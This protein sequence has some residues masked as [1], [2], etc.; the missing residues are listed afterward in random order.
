[1]A[2]AVQ[3]PFEQIQKVGGIMSL[4]DE[5][6][7]KETEGFVIMD[8]TTKSDGLGG[9]ITVWKEGAPVEVALQQDTATGKQ[10]AQALTGV[11]TY[12]VVTKKNI[13]FHYGDVIKRVRDGQV[14][15]ITSNSDN[16][17]TPESSAINMRQTTAEEYDLT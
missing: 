5:Y 12:T 11:R 9:V 17:E 13:D 14:F 8:K 6:M 15:R 7:Q 10:I 1:M 3:D 2:D 16:L 4:L